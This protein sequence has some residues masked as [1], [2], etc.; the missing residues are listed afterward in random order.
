MKKGSSATRK[1]AKQVEIVGAE[2]PPE[3]VTQMLIADI[4]R[5]PYQARQ[6]FELS[7]VLSTLKVRKDGTAE[8]GFGIHQALRIRRTRPDEV[9][10][11]YDGNEV[12]GPL[13]PY[14]LIDGERRWRSGRVAGLKCVPTLPPEDLKPSEILAAQVGSS[15]GKESLRPLEV[16][17]AIERLIAAKM[18]VEEIATRT[19]LGVRAI[20]KAAKLCTAADAVKMALDCGAITEAIALRLATIDDHAEQAAALKELGKNPTLRGTDEVLV[21]FHLVLAMDSAGFDP[22]DKRLKPGPCSKCPHNTQTQATLWSDLA[23]KARCTKR[24]CFTSKQAQAWDLEKQ[25]AQ[26]AKVDVIE[27]GRAEQLYGYRHQTEPRDANLIDLDGKCPHAPGKTWRDELG[28]EAKPTALV[29]AHGKT[30]EVIDSAQLPELLER[31]G[32]VEAAEAERK[33]RAALE[34]AERDEAER[35]ANAKREAE[36]NRA[37]KER[38]RALFLDAVE[39]GSHERLLQFFVLTLVTNEI[40]LFGWDAE[41]MA[42]TMDTPVMEKD[43]LLEY[44]IW[45]ASNSE[46]R[47]VAAR[48]MFSTLSDN[49]S[50]TSGLLGL[51][52]EMHEAQHA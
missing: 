1:A 2:R 49:W 19:G 17:Q 13:P 45:A 6:I 20:R 40:Q 30:H 41:R 11:D 38:A 34:Q 52:P 50:I 46:L 8:K 33:A 37:A 27:G 15:A 21:R 16:A 35:R 10:V 42:K 3:V 28:N 43:A 7:S 31:A 47:A 39:N 4:R 5:D 9:N 22:E 12:L 44:W 26:S 18:D 25:A 48:F 29:R 23:A 51:S 36:E 32:R 14:T 24:E